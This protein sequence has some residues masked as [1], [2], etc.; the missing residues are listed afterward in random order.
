MVE[1]GIRIAQLIGWRKGA[2]A[3]TFAVLGLMSLQTPALAET[4]IV[5]LYKENGMPVYTDRKPDKVIYSTITFGRPTAS[6]SCIGITEKAMQER[7]SHLQSLVSKHSNAHGVPA[8]LVRAVMR[9]ES[10]FDRKAVS[11]V[12]ARGLMQL[13]P[14]TAS[15]LGVRDSFDADQNIGGGVRYLR[16]MLQRFNNDTRLA[17]AAYNAGPEAVARHRGVP[18]FPETQR[19]VD[20][21]FAAYREPGGHARKKPVS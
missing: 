11:R 5:Y 10:C 14:A 8:G 7:A 2:R 18:P 20:R 13:M 21:V 6:A 3:A 9:V 15:E 1:T 12:G 17:V 4:K 16:K 19:Y